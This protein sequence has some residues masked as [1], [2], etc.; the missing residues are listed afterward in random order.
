M[1]VPLIT[2]IYSKEILLSINIAEENAVL[3]GNMLIF[4]IPGTIM[5]AINFQLM[6]FCTAQKIDKP[7]GISNIVSI[8]I[9]F[10]II[11]WLIEEVQVG[12][13]IF[14]ICK[15]IIELMNLIAILYSIFF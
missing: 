1:I 14:S 12:I 8:I 3:V 7:F 10:C 9:C 5:N 2:F 11:R 13:H 4:L 6:G 15:V